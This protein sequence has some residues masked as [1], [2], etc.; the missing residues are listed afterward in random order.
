MSSFFG[1]LTGMILFFISEMV[2]VHIY[3]FGNCK[4]CKYKFEDRRKNNDS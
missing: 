4:F 1:F 2:L 3:G